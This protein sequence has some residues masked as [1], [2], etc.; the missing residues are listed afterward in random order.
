[1]ILI[2]ALI[3]ISIGIL[4]FCSKY[5]FSFSHRL[6]LTPINNPNPDFAVLIPARDESKVIEDLF[7]SLKDQTRPVDP[8]SV[9]VIVESKDDP[10]IALAKKYH[11]KTI[12]RTHPEKQRKGY[13]LDEAVSI[14]LKQKQYDLYF[15]FDADN[16]LDQNY[17]KNMLKI[18]QKGY[19]I[20]IG[21]RKIKN[22]T[23]ATAVGSG[24]IFTIVNVLMNR[25]YSRRGLNCVAS[26]TGYYI[27]GKIINLE[28][29]FPFHTM[30]EDYEIS[31]YSAIHN[32]ST[33][34]DK[35]AIFYD[36]QPDTYSQYFFQR[37]RW[38]KGYFEARRLYTPK[39]F[40]KLSFK[41][42]NFNSIYV[43]LVGVYDFI[44]IVLGLILLLIN[45]AIKNPLYT[46]YEI[47]AVY[48]LLVF[49]TALLL[50]IEKYHLLFKIKL[51]T[52]LFH[53]LLLLTYIP[54]LFVVIF[55]R[56]LT[57]RRIKH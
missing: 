27:T 15:I 7:K 20:G 39:L 48:L 14:I 55:K 13:A 45:F 34:Y 38:E 29:G 56:N 2:L 21:C 6:K 44:F 22:L 19:D 28:K 16:R 52:L 12:I 9:Y 47:A 25:T 54:C 49:F 18:Y 51:K 42:P 4:L 53:P 23:S 35:K 11:Y 1:M 33:F 40:K 10:T 3:L 17:F 26:G 37:A 30:T 57:W 41:N 32:Y 31:L 8:S 50:K 24:L 43:L 36:A 46:L 5:L